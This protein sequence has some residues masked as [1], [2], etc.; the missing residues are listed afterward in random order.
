TLLLKVL[1][2]FGVDPTAS[3]LAV[4][5][6]PLP[7]NARYRCAPTTWG[8]EEPAPPP[9]AHRRKSRAGWRR[10]RSRRRRLE[11]NRA[12]APRGLVT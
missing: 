8:L 2:S 10:T 3:D 4:D 11:V 5:P 1:S 6:R 12:P 7:A 9:R